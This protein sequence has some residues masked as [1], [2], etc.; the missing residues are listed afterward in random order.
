MC[1]SILNN[2]ES[3]SKLAWN[4]IRPNICPFLNYHF[5]EAL[6]KSKSVGTESGWNPLYFKTTKSGKTAILPCYIK[7]NSSRSFFILSKAKP[8][9][10][11]S[12]KVNLYAKNLPGWWNW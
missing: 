5:I 8:Q 7:N 1:D 6:E 10:D 2:I 11:R 3:I 9:C 4:E 12:S